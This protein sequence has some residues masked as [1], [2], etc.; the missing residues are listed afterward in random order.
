MVP[1]SSVLYVAAPAPFVLIEY[2]FVAV[3]VAERNKV[4][5]VQVVEVV[6]TAVVNCPNT[7]SDLPLLSVKLEAAFK[8]VLLVDVAF[9]LIVQPPVDESMRRL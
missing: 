6:A 9:A 2:A 8:T 5:P 3:E 1:I 4:E 7:C